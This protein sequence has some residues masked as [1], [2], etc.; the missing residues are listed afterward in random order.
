MSAGDVPSPFAEPWEAQVFALVVSLREAGLFTADEWAR[1]LGAAI[2]PEGG[3]EAPADYAHWLAA[4]ETL[5]AGRGVTD[6]GQIAM[7][8]A[9]FLRAA[10]ATPH[11]SPILIENDPLFGR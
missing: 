11:G 5:L 2:R 10:Q 1:A 6:A 7:R 3:P 8:S 9:A 4:L